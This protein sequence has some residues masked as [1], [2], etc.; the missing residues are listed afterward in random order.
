MIS[1]VQG[2]VVERGAAHCV[3][4]VGGIGLRIAMST[5]AIASLP[6]EGDSVRVH[7]HLHVRE[8]ELSLF[9]FTSAEEKRLFELLITVSGVGPKV[10]LAALSSYAPGP[11]ADAIAGED[12]AV[13][14]S[15]PGIGPKTAQRIILELKD[16]VGPAVGAAT[17]DA[18]GPAGA[19]VDEARAA[20]LA[21]GFSAAEVSVALKDAHGT[22]DDPGQLVRHALRRLGGAS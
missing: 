2:E 5:T 13:V 19:S 22:A 7:V 18:R 9:G 20:L 10:A 4:A 17:S 11:L 8:D 3:V 12:V 1:F 6:H 16:K 21:M 15:V 14:S